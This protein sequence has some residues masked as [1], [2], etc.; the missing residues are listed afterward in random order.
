M[1]DLI[2]Q[3]ESA[4]ELE[5]NDCISAVVRRFN[6]LRKDREL[7]FLTLSADPETRDADF[8][9]TVSFIRSCFKRQDAEKNRNG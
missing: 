7:V 5:L 9:N 8:E 2:K 1:S 4:D 6:V 3:I